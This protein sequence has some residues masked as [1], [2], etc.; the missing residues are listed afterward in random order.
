MLRYMFMCIFTRQIKWMDGWRC[1][2]WCQS[3]VCYMQALASP[4]E[5]NGKRAAPNRP[6]T[7]SWNSRKSK[8]ICIKD[9]WYGGGRRLKATYM[10]L[11]LENPITVYKRDNLWE[12]K[13]WCAFTGVILKVQN[14]CRAF[15]L[16]GA[17]PP[18]SRPHRDSASGLRWPLSSPPDGPDPL[19]FARH[20]CLLATP[21]FAG[22]VFSSLAVW[23]SYAKK[24]MC[25]L[26]FYHFITYLSFRSCFM[27]TV[28]PP[29]YF[30]PVGPFEHFSRSYCYT[31]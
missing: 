31:S 14:L 13:G 22:A 23:W 24:T 29:I 30:R 18:E 16:L 8:I 5:E 19:N 6:C 21:L 3:N 10:W 15:R 9:I 11:L 7:L 27:S 4:R 28:T 17:S 1:I 12:I 25:C 2:V 26:L 20:L